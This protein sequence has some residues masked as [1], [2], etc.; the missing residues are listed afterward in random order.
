MIEHPIEKPNLGNKTT[1]SNELIE[2]ASRLMNTKSNGEPINEN[3]V[4]KVNYENNKIG[5]NNNEI[6]SIVRETV[7]DVLRENGLL[8]ESQSKSNEIF[9]FRVG[10]HIFEGK[11]TN[12][13]K[14]SK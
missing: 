9:K 12:I 7:E 2:K 10:S 4:Q 11:L 8:V 5:V 14:I 13:K 6:R 1:L 3:K